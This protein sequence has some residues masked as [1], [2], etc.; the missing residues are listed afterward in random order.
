MKSLIPLLGLLGL[1]GLAF[2]APPATA[3]EAE[4]FIRAEA[5]FQK[6]SAGDSGATAT[7]VARFEQLAAADSPHAPLYLAYL[8]AAQAMQGRD[9]WMPWT[10]MRATERGLATLDKAL[11]RLEDRHDTILLRQAPVAIETRLVAASTFLALPGLFHR[12]DDAKTV[13]RAALASPAF[14]AAPPAL[15]AQLHWRAAAAAARDRKHAEEIEQL[16]QVLAAEPSG[17]FAAAVRQR[18][19]E[20]GS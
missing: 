17:Q 20:S 8:G 5:L 18:L 16:R 2:F 7:A 15:R 19:Q 1:L 13:L 9:A 11:R 3:G 4:D 10:K 14:A 6:A 12:F